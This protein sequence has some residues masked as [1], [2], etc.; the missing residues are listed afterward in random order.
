M[1]LNQAIRILNKHNMWE[2]IKPELLK[3][4]IEIILQELSD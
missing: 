2:D 3:Q 1:P 4:A